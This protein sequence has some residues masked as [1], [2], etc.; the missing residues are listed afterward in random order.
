MIFNKSQEKKAVTYVTA[1]FQKSERI[2]I[3]ETKEKRSN[4]INRLYWIW[5]TLIG[6]DLGYS[7][8]EIHELF[9][10]KFGLKK[11]LVV[12]E[13]GI[14]LYI[15]ISTTKY[16]NTEMTNYMQKIEIFCNTE[17]NIN[18]PHPED[19]GIEELYE[20]YGN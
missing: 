7:K 20:K 16:N 11:E 4:H 12:N 6:S 18:L 19:L 5:C 1:L 13:Y 8:D 17:L 10:L 2:E 15:P 3:K 14:E 9:K